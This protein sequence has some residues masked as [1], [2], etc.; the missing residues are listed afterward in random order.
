MTDSETPVVYSSPDYSAQ[1]DSLLENEATI[2]EAYTTIQE[3]NETIINQNND[4]LKVE[5]YIF[6]VLCTLLVIKIF[7]KLFSVFDFA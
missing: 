2:I 4:I 7:G 5:L 1:I 6:F 3:Q